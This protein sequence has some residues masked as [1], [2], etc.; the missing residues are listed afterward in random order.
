MVT[1]FNYYNDARSLEHKTYKKNYFFNEG[2]FQLL[3]LAEQLVPALVLR[4]KKCWALM[5]IECAVYRVIVNGIYSFKL[6]R[7][8]AKSTYYGYHARPS[9]RIYGAALARRVSP[10]CDVGNLGEN[11][12]R[13]HRFG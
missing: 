5:L 8:V 4:R 12:S 7:I 3:R 11:L 9:V 2:N 10:K 13:Q 6:F 1:L